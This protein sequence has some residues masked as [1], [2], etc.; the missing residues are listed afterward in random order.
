MNQE[1]RIDDLELELRRLPGVLAAAIDQDGILRIQLHVRDPHSD[2]SLTDAATRIALRY[3][4]SSVAVEVNHWRDLST[5][6]GTVGSATTATAGGIGSGQVHAG[7]APTRPELVDLE[8]RVPFMEAVADVEAPTEAGTADTGE[9]GDAE[10]TSP[11]VLPT[12]PE[13]VTEP[14]PSASEIIDVVAAEAAEREQFVAREPRVRL[15]A[16]L[17][18]PD[19]DELEVHLTFNGQRSIG[20]APASNGVLGASEATLDALKVFVPELDQAAVWA[21]PMEHRDNANAYLVAT[22]LHDEAHTLHGLATGTSP[23]EAAAR[24]TLHALNRTIAPTLAASLN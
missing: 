12:V 8:P 23:I 5:L 19:T 1:P 21:R 22:E 18:F 16:V 15:L 4:D 6:G 20:R 14:A 2:P 13:Y 7:A 9:A 24:S 10:A 17:T 11:P 3:T